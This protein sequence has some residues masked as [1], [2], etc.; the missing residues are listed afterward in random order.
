MN[1]QLSPNLGRNDVELNKNSTTINSQKIESSNQSFQA[2][3]LPNVDGEDK[4]WKKWMWANLFLLQ[5]E[6]LLQEDAW[7]VERMTLLV[8]ENLLDN[9]Q[10]S[11]NQVWPG[12]KFCILICKGQTLGFGNLKHSESAVV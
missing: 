9:G 8:D 6:K 1:E 10:S 4:R 3:S 2:V 11:I 5:H 7:Q 12:D